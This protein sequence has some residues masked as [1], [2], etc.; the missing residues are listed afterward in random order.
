M[1]AGLP[2]NVLHQIDCSYEKA[3]DI[4]EGVRSLA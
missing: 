4:L 1:V 2:T 3:Y